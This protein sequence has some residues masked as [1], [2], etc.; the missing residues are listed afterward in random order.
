MDTKCILLSCVVCYDDIKNGRDIQ[1]IKCGHVFHQECIDQWFKVRNQVCYI[2]IMLRLPQEHH[3]CP[4]CRTTVASA[5]NPEKP[6]YGTHKCRI[7]YSVIEYC[8]QL[9]CHYMI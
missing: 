6:S 3:V 8:T 5:Q 7:Q 9:V 1:A 4:L 2:I